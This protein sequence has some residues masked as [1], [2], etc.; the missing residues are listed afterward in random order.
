MSPWKRS[1][2]GDGEVVQP[3]GQVGEVA[4]EA[5]PGVAPVDPGV[6]VPVGRLLGLGGDLVLEEEGEN[7][8][9]DQQEC[10]QAAQEDEDPFH[11][12]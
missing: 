5:E 10:E 3:Q 9:Q 8:E 2:V 4:E 7:Q 11:T 6:D 12:F 1:G